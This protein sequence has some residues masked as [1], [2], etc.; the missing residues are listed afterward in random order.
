MSTEQ[1]LSLLR[2]GEYVSVLNWPN[3]LISKYQGESE[4]SISGDDLLVLAIY[5]LINSD[6]SKADL[7]FIQILYAFLTTFI[8]PPE[9]AYAGTVIISAAMQ[10]Y[11]YLEKGLIE[12]YKNKNLADVKSIEQWMSRDNLILNTQ[13]N[14]VYLAEQ[15]A[16]F[17]KDL[18]KYKE[19]VEGIGKKILAI[20][21]YQALCLE[22]INLLSNFSPEQTTVKTGLRLGIAQS[23]HEYL[24]HQVMLTPEIKQEI[25][26]YLNKI[27]A[28]LEPGLAFKWEEAYLKKLEDKTIFQRLYDDSVYCL[29]F[30]TKNIINTIFALNTDEK[31]ESIEEKNNFP[32]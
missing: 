13:E 16:L 8:L 4:R 32:H 26:A 3:F 14:G 12:F 29:G 28:E 22:Y 5:E 23:L 17:E 11:V 1:F 2:Q 19:V 27:N 15:V 18:P 10:Y 9:K 21:S 25:M 20:A 6:F 7:E 31:S 24:C 30:F